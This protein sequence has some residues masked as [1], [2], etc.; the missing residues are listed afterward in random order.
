MQGVGTKGLEILS[1]PG[2]S[3]HK[4]RSWNSLDLVKCIQP[5]TCALHNKTHLL[6]NPMFLIYRDSHPHTLYMHML[7]FKVESFVTYLINADQ[8]ADATSTLSSQ[9]KVILLAN[10]TGSIEDSSSSLSCGLALF[11]KS[12]IT[13]SETILSSNCRDRNRSFLLGF[14]VEVA[15]S[16]AVT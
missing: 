2:G 1:H 9:T 8:L 11:S 15:R 16:L 6:I 7:L 13:G 3:S 10:W 14:T 5:Y 12:C 4:G